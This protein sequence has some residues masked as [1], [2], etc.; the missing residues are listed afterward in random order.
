MTQPRTIIYSLKERKKKTADG[1]HMPYILT[2]KETSKL[3]KTRNFSSPVVD[4]DS[5]SCC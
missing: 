5:N 1:E 3:T 2:H 4:Q